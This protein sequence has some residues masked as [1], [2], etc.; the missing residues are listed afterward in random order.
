MTD[1]FKNMIKQSNQSQNNLAALDQIWK[2]HFT[3]N[4]VFLS[5][6][7]DQQSDHVLNNVE[8]HNQVNELKLYLRNTSCI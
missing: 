6:S 7:I 8:I 2:T 5:V 1:G 4:Y 3:K